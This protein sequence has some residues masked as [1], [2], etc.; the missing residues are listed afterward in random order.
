MIT[1]IDIL[2]PKNG[3]PFPVVED[4]D[5]LGGFRVVS[6]D[7]SREAIGPKLKKHGMLCL[8]SSTKIVWSWNEYSVVWEQV[9]DLA[10]GGGVVTPAPSN[11]PVFDA[12]CPSDTIVGD[13]VYPVVYPNSITYVVHADTYDIDKLPSV[14]V[15]I[16]KPNSIT[17]KVQTHGLVTGVFYGL[18][19]GK[20][21][22]LGTN[23]RPVLTPP[24]PPPNGSV[25]HQPVGVALDP[26]TL[27]L[28]PSVNLTRVRG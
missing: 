7:A 21:Y 4:I 27:I 28:S 25:F 2:K 10:H 18:S 22:F 24:T 26:A 11:G 3:Q 8:V 14:G 15:I 19:P 16:E 17:C 1:L 23:S 6:T 5:L 20:R 12:E 9:L 13:L